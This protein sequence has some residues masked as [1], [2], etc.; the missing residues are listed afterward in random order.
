MN[1]QTLAAD[2]LNKMA[3]YLL[4]VNKIHTDLRNENDNTRHTIVMVKEFA[5]YALIYKK[6]GQTQ[7]INHYQNPISALLRIPT[8]GNK[9]AQL[10]Y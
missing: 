6:D 8:K 7:Y 3:D 10:D 5:D 9:L 1:S 4:R 2:Q